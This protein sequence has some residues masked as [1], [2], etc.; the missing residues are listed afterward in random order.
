M[1]YEKE[2]LNAFERGKAFGFA[3]GMRSVKNEIVYKQ[4]DKIIE[5]C[6]NVKEDSSCHDDAKKLASMII[7]D[8]NIAIGI[9]K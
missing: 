7:K 1:D 6:R 5:G 3:E 9:I 4:I 8:C 2:I